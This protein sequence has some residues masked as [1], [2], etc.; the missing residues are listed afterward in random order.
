MRSIAIGQPVSIEVVSGPT[1]VV[2]PNGSARLAGLVELKANVP[3]RVTLEVRGAQ[4]S[5]T[6]AF[7]DFATAQRVH[8]LGMKSASAYEVDVTL[9]DRAGNSV[10]LEPPLEA[11]TRPFPERFPM[12]EVVVSKPEKMAP[13]YILLDRNGGFTIIVDSAGEVVWYSPVGGNVTTRL[14]NGKLFYSGTDPDTG[15][16]DPYEL[17]MLG[18]S[19]RIVDLQDPGT[20]LHHE[21]FLTERGTWLSLTSEAVEVPNYPTSTTDPNAPREMAS[22]EDQYLVEFMPDGTVLNAWPL[23]NLLDPTRIGYLSLG[24]TRRGN[25]GWS[26]SN[27]A[28]HDPRGDSIIVSVRHQNAVV[29]I[30]RTS[31]DLKWILGNHAN[32]GPAFQPFL[33]T[34][35]G[36][37]FAWQYAQHAMMI[38]PSGTLG[39]F[40]N[41]NDRASPF[42]GQIPV[43]PVANYSRAVEFGINEETMEVR[44]V[45]EYGA[46]AEDTVRRLAQRCR[47]AQNVEYGP[48]YVRQCQRD[49]WGEHP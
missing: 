26:H 49:R 30:D 12:I 15:E 40:D 24:N 4:E 47:L 23:T 13:G 18:V 36:E 37:P 39:L 44:Q 20:H 38:T 11:Q 48:H 6:V 3:V 42:D 14:P 10:K 25:K 9:T 22:I 5:W 28:L 8:V 35:V 33:L 31:G 32:W 43:E 46:N 34:P 17:D 16:R 41:G 27:A 1:L 7:P 2:D 19:K 29:K 21:M 45:W